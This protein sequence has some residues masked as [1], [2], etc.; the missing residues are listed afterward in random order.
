MPRKLAPLLAG[1]AL[2]ACIGILWSTQRDLAAPVMQRSMNAA[3]RI[4]RVPF[5][6]PKA[7]MTTRRSD[8]RMV[9]VNAA[10]DNPTSAQS[11]HEFKA[12]L[13]D[14]RMQDMAAYKGKV[15]LVQNV[16]TL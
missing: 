7:P 9:L 15:V 12:P 5:R 16:A 10:E 4:A 8:A 3:S 11:L 2:V 14:G 6:M 1:L 13:L